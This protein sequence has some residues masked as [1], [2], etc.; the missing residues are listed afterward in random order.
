MND[1][2]QSMNEEDQS[3]VYV[4]LILSHLYHKQNFSDKA[5]STA[6]QAIQ[7]SL[8]ASMGKEAVLLFNTFSAVKFK[9]ELTSVE[10]MALAAHLMGQK[11]FMDAASCYL[12]VSALTNDEDEKLDIQKKYIELAERVTQANELQVALKLYQLFLKEFPGSTL[13]GFVKEQELKGTS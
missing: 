8:K 5:L 11:Q 10:R 6:N 1:T 4:L 2:A 13:T 9:L 12:T 7:A 3:N